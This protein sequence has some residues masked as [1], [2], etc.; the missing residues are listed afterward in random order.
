[1]GAVVG[2][3]EMQRHAATLPG[4]ENLGR[5]TGGGV[6]W[7]IQGPKLW[8]LELQMHY[9]GEPGLCWFSAAVLY[10]NSH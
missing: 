4:M 7:G 8:Q 3:V 1:M 5:L 6:G 9:D 10:R 2:P